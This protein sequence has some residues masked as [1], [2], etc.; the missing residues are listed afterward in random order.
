M[1]DFNSL[2][3]GSCFCPVWPEMMKF[4]FAHFLVGE[5]HQALA[6]VSGQG[7]INIGRDRA[8]GPAETGLQ[9]IAISQDREV[10]LRPGCF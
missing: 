9:A 3:L 5:W 1:T 6:V 4:V 7:M 8:A 10:F 2:G